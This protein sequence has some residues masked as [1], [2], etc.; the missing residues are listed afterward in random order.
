MALAVAVKPRP[1]HVPV[2]LAQERHIY[3]PPLDLQVADVPRVPLL[4]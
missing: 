1:E 4:A 2:L 3:G